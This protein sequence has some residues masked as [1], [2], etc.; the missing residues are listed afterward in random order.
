[1]SQH[2]FEAN[3]QKYMVSICILSYNDDIVTSANVIKMVRFSNIHG[4]IRFAPLLVT[5]MV[6][7]K[8][9][10]LQRTNLRIKDG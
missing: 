3:R 7:R 4:F 5:T 8:A 6:S 9:I 10:T 2:C 1:M